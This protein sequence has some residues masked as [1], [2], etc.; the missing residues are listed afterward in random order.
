VTDLA[1]LLETL[2]ATGGGPGGDRFR[3]RMIPGL[4]GHYIGRDARGA[5][6]LLLK[7]TDSGMRAPIRLEAIEVRFAMPCLVSESN[8]AEGQ[9]TLTVVICTAPDQQIERYFLHVCETILRIVGPR[10]SFEAVSQAMQRLVDLF[11][12][13]ALPPLRSLVGLIGEMIVLTGSADAVMAAQAWRSAVDDRFDFATPALRLE[14][15]ASAARRRAHE[16][17]QE[18]CS[19]PDGVVGIL[20]SLFV[21]SSGGGTS[22]LDLVRRIEGRLAGRDDLITKVQ[23]AV[24]GTLGSSLP[25]AL[26]T[27]FDE[28]LARASLQFYDLANVPAIRGALPPGVSRVRFQSDL[29]RMPPLDRS[30]LSAR[31]DALAGLLPS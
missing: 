25:T 31:G 19:P 14:V 8:G 27:R 6:C 20:A 4:D 5:A 1:A 12:R 26:T 23:D 22:L 3:V 9:E 10:P 13:L 29:S 16:F 15:K 30:A 7:S 18:Q 17:S 24:S 11:R 21:E 2:T 28:G